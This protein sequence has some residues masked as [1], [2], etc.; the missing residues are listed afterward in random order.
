MVK[1]IEVLRQFMYD[2]DC[3]H[4]SNEVSPV[5]CDMCKGECILAFDTLDELFQYIKTK[6]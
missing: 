4:T 6:S 1:A 3:G 2:N 5:G